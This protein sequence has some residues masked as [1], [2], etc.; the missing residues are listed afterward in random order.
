MDATK[1]ANLLMQTWPARMAQDAWSAAKLPCDVYQAKIETGS[2]EYYDRASTLAGLLV[3]FPGTPGGAVG[4]GMRALPRDNYLKPLK[5][6]TNSLYR[7]MSPQSA[8]E[9]LPSSNVYA[10]YGPGGP[11]RQ[12]YA[13]TPDLALGQ[14]NN[15]G[16]RVHY[17]ADAFEGQI[18]QKPMSEPLFQ[19]RQAEYEASPIKGAN[20]RD[21]VN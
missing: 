6:Y 12:F 3:G 19:S 5:E 18:H 2:P 7:E 9:T 4:S 1:I 11:A 17:N 14:G 21:N 8:L 16:V 10:G 13:D 20:L 15:K